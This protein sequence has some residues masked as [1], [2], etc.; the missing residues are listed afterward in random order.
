MSNNTNDV[1][2]SYKDIAKVP[3]YI[4]TYPKMPEYKP[5]YRL[6]QYQNSVEKS[7]NDKTVY[8]V[9]KKKTFVEKIKRAIAIA[10]VS[11][12][13]LTGAAFALKKANVSPKISTSITRISDDDDV[14]ALADEI[15]NRYGYKPHLASDGIHVWYD[16]PYD[17]FKRVVGVEGEFYNE[18]AENIEI[19]LSC[20]YI[21]R[22]DPEFIRSFA[23]HCSEKRGE[24]INIDVDSLIGVNW[25][26]QRHK[27]ANLQREYGSFDNYRRTLTQTKG[28][29]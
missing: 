24:D 5:T 17:I 26:E 16:E 1:D 20:L 7:V 29:K 14:F 9:T 11:V 15:A 3:N 2:M 8:N 4:P 19:I 28:G 21:V 22:N 6:E 18:P 10:T 13:L 27:L 12:I 25:E 23:S